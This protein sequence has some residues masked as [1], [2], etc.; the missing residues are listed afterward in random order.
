MHDDPPDPFDQLADWAEKT[1]RK[2]RAR[3]RL[4]WLKLIPPV[5]V[6]V[7]AA[8]GLVL[9]V[10]PL[11]GKDSYA[12]AAVPTG[13]TVTTS[14][15]AAPTDPFAGTAAA[16]YP[17]GDAGI[18]LPAAKAVPHFS[19][20]QVGA[21]LRKVRGAMS[22]ARLDDTMLIK[23][24][25][26]RFIAMFAPNQGAALRKDF[27]GA[28]FITFAT[29]IDPAVRLDPAEKPR[30]SGRVTY[31][32]VTVDK[33][34]TLRV[35]TNFVWVYAFSRSDRPIV[36]AHDEIQWDFPA[37]DN[38]RSGDRGMWLGS[39]RAYTAP[40]DCKAN[41]RGLL[42]PTR[43]DGAAAP[44]PRPTEDQDALLKPDHSLEIQDNC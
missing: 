43:L 11:I 32:S 19:A 10:R 21:A 18:T 24:D 5:V 17:K 15:K 29:W 33:I 41:D 12:T 6:G 2:V 42:A 36:V 40:V 26:G 44:D 31:S 1:E 13:I 20:D 3:R 22:A 30:V 35:T 27:A 34:P 8:V 25:P 38:L 14:A 9:A 23:H 39:I 37:T 28:E 16:N 4:T 7:A